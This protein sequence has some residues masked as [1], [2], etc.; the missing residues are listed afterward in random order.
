MDVVSNI[1][2]KRRQVRLYTVH[3][4]LHRDSQE[5]NVSDLALIT[6]QTT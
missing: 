2:I 4:A 3:V 5:D 1:T 6:I